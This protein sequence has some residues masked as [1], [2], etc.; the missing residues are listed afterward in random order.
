MV[1]KYWSVSAEEQLMGRCNQC[2]PV[3]KNLA[4]LAMLS[5][6][7]GFMLSTKMLK[8]ANSELFALFDK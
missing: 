5:S 2:V 6:W 3:Q 1:W 4:I 8:T 7:F